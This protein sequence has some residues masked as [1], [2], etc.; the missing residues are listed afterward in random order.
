MLICS[1]EH[2]QIWDGKVHFRN[3]ASTYR[4]GNAE[5][6]SVQRRDVAQIRSTDVDGTLH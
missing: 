4:Q 3:S 5:L 1:N 6:T 2:V